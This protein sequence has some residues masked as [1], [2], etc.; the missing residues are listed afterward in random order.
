MAVAYFSY[1]LVVAFR[2]DVL[3]VPLGPDS[4]M[5]WGLLAGVGVIGFGFV[6]TALYVLY[7]NARFDALTRQLKE[8]LQ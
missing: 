6:L 4:V 1:I 3:G 8:A 7:A 2:P 5:T